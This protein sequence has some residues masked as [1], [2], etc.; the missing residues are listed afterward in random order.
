LGKIFYSKKLI[1]QIINNKYSSIFFSI[2]KKGFKLADNVITFPEMEIIYKDMWMMQPFYRRVRQWLVENNYVDTMGDAS[3]ESSMEIMYW[4]RRGSTVDPNEN[5]L[6]IWW[7]T[8]KNEIPG[9]M[10]SKFYRHF[11][12][13]NWY[14]MQM[15]NREIMRDGKK[16]KVQFGELRIVIKPRIE[17]GTLSKTPILKYF[18]Y[19]FRTR[20]IKKNLEENRKIL[21][22]DAYNL[23]STIKRYLALQSF[24][25]PEEAFHEK[26]DFI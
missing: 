14:I 1:Y 5:E 17:V 22:Q 7:R 25:P 26:F 15:V 8:M 20:L 21:Y 23:Q 10:G 6:R 13:I 2:L 3:M 4:M 18:D 24:Q 16:E 12:D 11:L 19:W 9:G